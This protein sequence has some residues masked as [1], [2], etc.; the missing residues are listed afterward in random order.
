MGHVG[1]LSLSPTDSIAP[2]KGSSTWPLPPSP[3]APCPSIPSPLDFITGETEYIRRPE[4]GTLSDGLIGLFYPELQDF[5]I[6]C[7]WKRKASLPSARE[8]HFSGLD[9]IIEL[10]A[11]NC[12]TMAL[13]NL[14]LEAL[15]LHELSHLGTKDVEVKLDGEIEIIQVPIIQG[16]DLESFNIEVE[17]YGLWRYGLQKADRAFQQGRLL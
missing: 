7:Y 9:F 4:L 17:T 1:R 5:K 11:D 8:K 2:S 13:T 14:G 6:G 15:M 12:R 3:S 16:H 10:S